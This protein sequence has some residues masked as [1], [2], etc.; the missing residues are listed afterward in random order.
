MQ[1]HACT[2]NSGLACTF[3]FICI[4]T[5][6]YI[7]CFYFQNWW[8]PPVPPTKKKNQLSPNCQS[9]INIQPLNFILFF[10]GFDTFELID[11]N[12]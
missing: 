12:S 7:Q 3:K 9:T 2:N 10:I 4:N 5:L 8:T 6:C 1:L 11:Q